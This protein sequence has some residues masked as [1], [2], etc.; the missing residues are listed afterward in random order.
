MHLT[1]AALTMPLISGQ[2]QTIIPAGTFSAPNGSLKGNGPWTLNDAD[3]LA[4]VANANSG[5]D[6]VVDY[7]HQTLLSSQN[8][9]PAPA[10]GWLLAGGFSWIPDQ[11]VVATQVRWTDEAAEMIQEGEYR[12]LSPVF[13]YSPEGVPISLMSVALTNTP[14]LTQLQELAVAATNRGCSMTDVK[15]PVADTPTPAPAITPVTTPPQ[16]ALTQAPT[17]P[18]ISPSG[19]IDPMI[20]VLTSQLINAREDAA[21]ARARLAEFEKQVTDGARSAMVQAALSDGRLLPAMAVWASGLPLGD[22]QTFLNEAKPIAALTGTQTQGVAPKNAVTSAQ[23]MSADDIAICKQ[24]GIT[25]ERFV[26]HRTQQ[27]NH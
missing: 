5:V 10:A 2:P 27:G 21:L 12:F 24:L 18:A 6:V 7:E 3:G 23:G 20:A 22:L 17:M 1:I 16:A 9:Q 19:A 26:A 14:A 15:A 13:S 4:L 25:H 8:G 11:G